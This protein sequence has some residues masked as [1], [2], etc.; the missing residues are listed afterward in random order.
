MNFQQVT[1]ATGLRNC[2]YV[3]VFS[4]AHV[5]AY[6]HMHLCVHVSRGESI[7]QKMYCLCRRIRKVENKGSPT[8]SLLCPLLLP[9]P[10]DLQS[11]SPIQQCPLA[12][13]DVFQGLQ[14]ETE[15][16]NRTKLYLDI[17]YIGTPKV[18]FNLSVWY[19]KTLITIQN[20]IEL[21]QYIAIEVI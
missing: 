21:Y 4:H 20:K 12:E 6:V 18:K 13:K 5:H 19:S 2:V 8:Q 11:I 15:T 17:F 7:L 3:Y 14:C 16:A 9:S 1:G 10:E